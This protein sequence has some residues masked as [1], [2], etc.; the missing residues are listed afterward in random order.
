M[1]SRGSNYVCTDETAVEMRVSSTW[2]NF[3]GRREVT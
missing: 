2:I 1:E 3:R